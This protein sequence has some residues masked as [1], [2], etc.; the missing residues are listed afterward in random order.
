[1]N[2]PSRFLLRWFVS[3]LGLWIAAGI[4]GSGITYENRIGVIIIAGL[5]LAIINTIIKPL[6]IIFSLPAILLTLG[7]FM[8]VIN[9]FTVL[10]ASK[11]YHSLH[12]TNFWAA[13]FA[14]IMIGLVNY[15]VSTIL[16]E[17]GNA[18]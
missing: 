12:V 3:S 4:L 8:I 18:K 17:R 16:E 14:G 5:I 7:L 9:G 6:L 13:M 1:M 10:L 15:L 2:G 11:F